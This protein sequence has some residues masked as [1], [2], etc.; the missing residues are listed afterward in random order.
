[1]TAVQALLQTSVTDQYRGRVFGARGTT[2]AL[3]GLLGIIL[4]GA[5]GERFGVIG[6]LNMQGWGYVVAG[7]LL[8][9][10][11]QHS[12]TTR[13]EARPAGEIQSVIG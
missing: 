7:I 1:M 10:L 8:L 11:L 3:L 5:F 9:V 6:V 13:P 2:M 12:Q 4:A